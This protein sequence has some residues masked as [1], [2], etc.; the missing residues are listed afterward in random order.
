M[1]SIK[2]RHRK[3]L[4]GLIS[5]RSVALSG[6]FVAMLAGGTANA[7]VAG[8]TQTTNYYLPFSANDNSVELPY[9]ESL[10]LSRAEFQKNFIQSSGIM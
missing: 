3:A 2:I 7:Q 9:P 6:M 1:K 5:P 4:K 10:E 8:T